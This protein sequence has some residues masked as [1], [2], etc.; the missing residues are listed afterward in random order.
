MSMPV[1]SPPAVVTS[2]H[3]A[4]TVAASLLALLG[5]WSWGRR[6]PGLRLL[7]V[8]GAVAGAGTFVSLTFFAGI[9]VY[10]GLAPLLLGLVG[11]LSGRATRPRAVHRA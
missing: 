6:L 1:A 4:L 5:G 8:L 10:Y 11:V 7:A 3:W 2:L 9:P